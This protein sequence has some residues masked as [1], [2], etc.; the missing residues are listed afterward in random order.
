MPKPLFLSP[1]ECQG[2]TWHPPQNLAFAADEALIPLHAGE[3]AKAA[4]AMPLAIVKHKRSW[5]LVGVCGVEAEHNLF[6]KNGQWLGHY[7]PEWLACYPFEMIAV[8]EK[9]LVVL[10]KHSPLM[11]KGSAGEPFFSEDGK[12]SEAVATRVE[13]LKTTYRRQQATAQTLVALASAGVITAWP[14]AL[15]ERLGMSLDGLH[16]IDEKALAQLDDEAF[17]EL[18]RAGALP[19]AY[20]V[21][22]A[23][24]QTHLLARL[25]R[26]T[27]AP[28]PESL[29][30]LFDEDDD[31]LNFEFD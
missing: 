26:L 20:A 19:F 21:N 18:R 17:I 24:T 3:L 30:A 9:G 22:L 1:K 23:L 29:D 6:I 4:A 31:E 10:D 8:G 25:A 12:M 28:A 13:M 16:M 5:R 15:R 14:A 2:K 7:R 27:P 11:D